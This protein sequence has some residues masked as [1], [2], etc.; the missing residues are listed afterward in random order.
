M[1]KMLKITDNKFVDPDSIV[2]AHREDDGSIF[3]LLMSQTQQ[4]ARGAANRKKDDDGNVVGF[5]QFTRANVTV[6][7]KPEYAD[8]VIAYFEEA[9]ALGNE[10]PAPVDDD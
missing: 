2:Y 8:A 6:H 3:L 7:C 1:K 9:A 4:P 10:A 5:K